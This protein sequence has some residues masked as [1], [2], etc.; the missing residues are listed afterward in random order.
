MLFDQ[1]PSSLEDPSP[2]ACHDVVQVVFSVTVLCAP[3]PLDLKVPFPPLILLCISSYRAQP[4]TLIV[5]LSIQLT[6]LNVWTGRT[7]SHTSDEDL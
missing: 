1:P 4:L 2:S 3:M 5:V 7:H 6:F